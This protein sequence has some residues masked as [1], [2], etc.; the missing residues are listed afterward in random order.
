MVSE[1]SL[2][3]FL[4]E[5]HKDP[6]VSHPLFHVLLTIPHQLSV[7][8]IEALKARSKLDCEAELCF[9]ILSPDRLSESLRYVCWPGILPEVAPTSTPSTFFLVT[10]QCTFPHHSPSSSFT[11]PSPLSFGPWSLWVK[12]WVKW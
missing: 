3:S 2:I 10:V 7:I 8:T 4:Q 11:I 1:E 6:E 5:S 12:L 9:S